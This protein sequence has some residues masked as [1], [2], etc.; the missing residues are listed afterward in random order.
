MAGGKGRRHFLFGTAEA[1]PDEKRGG[2]KI[3]IV[4]AKGSREKAAR[5]E[6]NEGIFVSRPLRAG[7]TSAAP[8]GLGLRRQTVGCGRNRA[9]AGDSARAAGGLSLGA[10][11]LPSGRRRVFR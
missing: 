11:N 10:A 8:T 7:L 5:K 4:P 9:K 1:G 2:G 3:V 6:W